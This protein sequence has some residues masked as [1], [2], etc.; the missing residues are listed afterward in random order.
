MA[1]TGASQSDLNE[2]RELSSGTMTGRTGTYVLQAEACA[3]GDIEYRLIESI[4]IYQAGG[5][6]IWPRT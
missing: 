3:K 2:R 1:P 6:A 4:R 5:A